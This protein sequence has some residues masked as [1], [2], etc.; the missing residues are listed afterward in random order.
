MAFTG[1]Q[2]TRLCIA[3]GVTEDGYTMA[4]AH[5]RS[6][7]TIGWQGTGLRAVLAG[8][9][10][11]SS[12]LCATT[13]AAGEDLRYLRHQGWTTE[14]GLPQDSV[15]GIVQTA[16]GY[17]WVG[18]EGGLARF[19][20]VS[21]R[22]FQPAA[23]SALASGD[24]SS[25]LTQGNDL[26]VG[27]ADGLVRVR[28]GGE[29]MV[30]FGVE[31][32]LPSATIL[33]LRDGP[34]LHP[35]VQ[36]PA[37]WSV[38]QG[39]RFVPSSPAPA[40]RPDQPPA[41]GA[42]WSTDAA[43]VSWTRGEHTQHWTLG[44]N[45]PGSR[46][47]SLLAQP[48]EAWAGTS[49]GL[50]LL[51]PTS[52]GAEAV[53]ALRGDTILV[54]FHDREGDLWIGTESSG[55]H[56]LRSVRFRTEPG[57]AGEGVVALTESGGSVWAGT[58]RDGVRLLQDGRASA[59]AAP[60][61][62]S[63]V[64]LSM[65]PAPGGEVWVGTPDG[66]NRVG[67]DGRV[68]QISSADGLPDDYVLALEDDGE[69]GVW[70]GTRRGLAHVR[71]TLAVAQVV[72]RE[73]GL[74]GDLVG[75]LRRI[76]AGSGAG[77][78]WIGTSGGV[79]LRSPDG[80][81]HPAQ[82][83]PGPGPVRALAEDAQGSVWL[84]TSEGWVTRVPAGAG[85]G[86][87]AQVVHGG[88]QSLVVDGGVVWIRTDRGIDT[89][90]VDDFL[91]C[92]RL[93]CAPAVT[94]YGVAD[95]MPSAEVAGGASPAA[96]HMSNGELWFGT[97][98]GVAIAEAAGPISG[99]AA[100]PVVI[101]R[102][103][104]D[105]AELAVTP[106]APRGNGEALRIPYGPVRFSIEY[107]GLSFAAPSRVRYRYRL[108]GLD[109]GWT[110]A[111]GRR[112]ATYTNLRS[113]RYRF[114]V[115]AA[116]AN[117]HW[118]ESGSGAVLAF[119]V[120]PPVYRRW[121]FVLLVALAGAGVVVGLYLLRLRRLRREFDAVL[122]ERNRMAREIHD[123]LAQDFV[124]VSLKLD[125]VS[126][127]LLQ[128]KTEAAQEQVRE[129]RVLVTEGLAE[130]RQSIW[131]LRA[132]AAADSLPARFTR[133]VGRFRAEGLEVRWKVGGAYRQVGERVE[134]EVLRVGQEALENVR[135][136]AGVLQVAVELQY[137]RDM[138]VLTVEDQGRGFAMDEAE[139]L[140]GHYGVRGMQ[141]RA[142]AVGG[143]LQV[144][145]AAGEGT[146]VQLVCPIPEA[147]SEVEP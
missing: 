39:T 99:E 109:S 11:L 80:T 58:R 37:G 100:P 117:G 55:L 96:W 79:S 17:L 62:T 19:D 137:R 35:V 83:K 24:I 25:L 111:G 116:D 27:T 87:G 121:W 38:W 129:A 71:S 94:G 122:R 48:A 114:Q 4:G 134:S 63:P 1:E 138:L 105:G 56:V 127:L 29:Q 46:V 44:R 142:A 47:E 89:M 42:P 132:N 93:G 9:A 68:R 53:P 143:Q 97:R 120:V 119:H 3:S 73:D 115:Q 7:R 112:S 16:D 106:P 136:H 61:M 57:L 128:E 101:E 146:R 66:L 43:G 84:A 14:D 140:E 141:E 126:R 41:P 70:A 6:E 147:T 31:S 5:R 103:T 10:L 131:G 15:H 72:T 23:G 34:D 69:G 108:E 67:R 91:R 125:I 52:P 13:H 88:V 75:A 133:L 144:T 59:V 135:R 18:T 54:L 12:A 76:T 102:F 110:E 95:G 81:I 49:A 30:R 21:F 77:T 98:H 22:V 82:V 113:G 107:A 32:G 51:R 36:T 86:L 104:A 26:W 145:T 118:A 33:A 90:R 2:A 8:L 124:G 60:A 40:Q 92:A 28:N 50:F 64:V 78:L 85:A 123:T 20:G 74:A 65:A 139:R 130:A 45:L